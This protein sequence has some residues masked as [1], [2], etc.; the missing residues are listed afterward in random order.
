MLLGPASQRCLGWPSHDLQCFFDPHVDAQTAADA[1][2]S[3]LPSDV[4]QAGSF[5]GDNA[6]G[7]RYPNGSCANLV[8]SSD[9][10]A[11]VISDVNPGWTGTR[12]M[13]HFSLY[14]GN[15]TSSD[16]ADKPYQPDSVHLALVGLGSGE[17]I[18]KPINC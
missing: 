3:L 8:Y 16:G 7:S 1:V 13:V 4:E 15:T 11:A 17:I 5:N 18:G 14:S 9:A 12:N 6:D 10:L 2:T